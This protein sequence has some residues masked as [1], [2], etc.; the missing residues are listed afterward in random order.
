MVLKMGILLSLI[1][2]HSLSIF[3]L[4]KMFLEILHFDR[5]DALN[6]NLLPKVVFSILEPGVVKR[7]V[8]GWEERQIH[9]LFLFS[10]KN[11]NEY[12]SE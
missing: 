12:Y 9:S 11:E 2:F 3:Y 1:I 8:W 5:M 4:N 7:L 6:L 10:L